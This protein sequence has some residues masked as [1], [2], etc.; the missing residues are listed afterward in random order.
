MK[1]AII[2]TQPN[3]PAMD[4][5]HKYRAY[6]LNI[7]SEIVLP[8]LAPGD[9]TADVI[10]R[11]GKLEGLPAEAKDARSFY[12]VTDDG[13]YLAWEGV[14]A[15][16]VR[17]GNEIIIDPLPG[18]EEC[19]LRLF[20]LGSTLAMLLHQRGDLVVL[21]ASMVAI[22]NNAIGFVGDK[23]AGKSTMAAF[24]HE[25][26]HR[27]MADDVLAIDL[28]AGTPEALPGFP[29][30]KLWPDSVATLGHTPE[31]LPKLRP[32]LEKRSLR[33]DGNFS[34]TSVPL[35]AIY[36]LDQGEE[37]SIKKLH[38]KQALQALM[39]HWYGARFGTDLLQGLGLT[40]HFSQCSTLVNTVPFFHLKRPRSLPG[41]S[42]LARLIENH[43]S[44]DF[45]Q[46]HEG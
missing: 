45:S 34:Q 41:L 3:I 43:V 23:G 21:H 8:E 35:K 18:V 37:P 20:I 10:I 38:P 2:A 39:P 17:N 36:M 7:H 26:G 5:S 31:E 14:G 25:R 9:G 1:N 6:D 12:K 27:L 44:R 22:K 30:L 28:R 33:L 46:I 32:E 16:L 4:K 15:F 11:L 42:D 29:H 19:I 40:T 24:L 13:I